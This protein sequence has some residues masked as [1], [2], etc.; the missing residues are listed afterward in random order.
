MIEF[1]F[2]NDEASYAKEQ[3]C[4]DMADDRTAL[5]DQ[6]SVSYI[7]SMCIDTFQHHRFEDLA[8]DVI[9]AA[10]HTAAP[11]VEPYCS[12]FVHIHIAECSDMC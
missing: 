7:K 3:P 11:H 1:P 4:N 2:G 6:H 8:L 5:F 9:W 10:D 12:E